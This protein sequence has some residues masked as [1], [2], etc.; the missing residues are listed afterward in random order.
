MQVM[1]HSPPQVQLQV[2]QPLLLSQ[3]LNLRYIVE[4]DT[5]DSLLMD[6]PNNGHL[7]NNRHYYMS[8]LKSPYM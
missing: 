2:L 4:H 5:V 1:D 7:P 6:T 8:Q 3:P